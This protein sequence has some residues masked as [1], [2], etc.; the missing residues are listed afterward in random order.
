MRQ[1]RLFV[2]HGTSGSP[3]VTDGVAA[4][5]TNAYYSV[6]IHNQGGSG[7]SLQTANTGTLTGV[8]EVWATD[9]PDPILTTDADWVQVTD[10]LTNPAAGATNSRQ[11][12]ACRAALI[13]VKYIN[14]SGTGSVFAY[15]TVNRGA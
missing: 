14:A 5:S 4:S 8:F 2:T 6:P 10:T 9:K 7:C 12:L 13:R 15:A 1:Q 3:L 11:D